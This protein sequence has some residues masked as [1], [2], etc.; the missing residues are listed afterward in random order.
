MLDGI[1]ITQVNDVSTKKLKR[2]QKK[3]IKKYISIEDVRCPVCKGV[4]NSKWFNFRSGNVV[5]FVAECWSGHLSIEEP[6]YPRHIFYF[7]IETPECVL[8]HAKG[9]K[10]FSG[11]NDRYK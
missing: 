1:G 3:K 4:I 9:S 8:V 10:I 2:K 5:E 6:P 7:Q 11:E